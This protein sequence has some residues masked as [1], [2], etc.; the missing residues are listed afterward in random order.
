MKAAQPNARQNPRGLRVGLLLISVVITV[1]GCRPADYREL[2]D[3]VAYRIIADKQQNAFGKSAPFSIATPANTLRRRL[4]LDQNLQHSTA[5]SVSS[6]DVEPIEQWPDKDY[7]TQD[8]PNEPVVPSPPEDGPLVLTLVDALQIAAFEN[9]DYRT[10]K[11]RVFRT[12]LSLDLEDNEFRS[13][14]AGLVDSRY[15]EQYQQTVVVA[16]DGRTDQATVRG[17]ETSG[18][19]ALDQQFKN[20]LTFSGQVGLDLVSLLTQE[21]VFSRGIFADI[22][23]TLPLARGSGEFVVTEPLKQAEREVVYSL[24][25]FERFKREFAVDIASSYLNVLQRLDSVENAADNYERLIASTRRTRR[26]ADAGKIS[27]I[28]VD[29]SYQDE[30]RA[31]NQWISALENYDRTLDGFKLTLGLPPDAK[32]S[33]TGPSSIG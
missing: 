4:M 7:L 16:A 30:L 20:G 21:K 25:D 13:T 24:Y 32:W 19:L 5:I 11:E 10:E 23:M 14:W 8:D 12:A 9:R 22:T 27:E 6:K 1:L 31:R 18:V 33:W 26:L 17:S 29:Q 3:K 2:A 15:L 28:Q